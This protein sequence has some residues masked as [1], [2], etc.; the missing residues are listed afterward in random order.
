MLLLLL[1]CNN[2]KPESIPPD[3]S[4][5][6]KIDTEL[7]PDDSEDSPQD[8]EE[9]DTKLHSDTQ[10]ESKHS[11]DTEPPAP[12]YTGL[13]LYPTELTVG[14]GAIL[15][16][17]SIA[18]DQDGKRQAMLP[19]S[20]SS[21]DPA[22]VTVDAAGMITAVGEGSTTIRALLGGV[23][24]SA[25]FTVRADG[26]AT[27][28]VIRGDSGDAIKGVD[29]TVTDTLGNVTTA[30]TDELGQASI[31]VADGGAVSLTAYKSDNF[32][33]ISYLGTVSRDMLLLMQPKD[34]TGPEASIYGKVD[35]SGVADAAWDEIVLGMA[36]TSVQGDLGSLVVDSLFSED[37]AIN[38]I[39]FDVTAPSNL[40]VEDTAEDFYTNAWEGVVG[41]WGLAGPLKVSDLP[42]G[43]GAGEA[44]AIMVANLDKF[45]WDF[46]GGGVAD[47]DSEIELDLA[48]ADAFSDSFV[49]E[50]PALPAGFFGSEQ[51]FL[52]AA[53]ED[54]SD[55][56]FFD[57]FGS[58]LAGDRT[59]VKRVAP[60]TVANS[61]G[62]SVLIYNQV[63][64]LGSGGAICSSV[65]EVDGLVVVAPPLQDV[66]TISWDS[67]TLVAGYVADPDASYVRLR[68][69][70]SG[71]KQHD[72]YVPATSWTGTVPLVSA[73]WETSK[74][75][76]E[77]VALES[78]WGSFEDRV[79]TGDWEPRN[80]RA[81]S[82]ARTYMNN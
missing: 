75:D 54:A 52:M 71:K 50:L 16:L 23:E 73:D 25:V 77:V 20:F 18:T 24:G 32:V 41:V 11:E 70:D 67:S 4:E 31:A 29:I 43:A 12:V 30:S 63:G 78:S 57:G 26:M 72:I 51:Y 35:F 27:V 56:W 15:T 69:L 3:D 76:L 58:G 49:V 55:G 59:E 48:P 7:I 34:N 33:Q 21:D 2:N 64:G 10:V 68:L 80:Q 81:T 22:I 19:E 53:E 44:L 28:T 8:S 65:A 1:A 42:L 39:G 17:R 37:R 66:I 45:V 82:M 14:L 79:R 60:G 62:S 40:F 5:P 36:G 6:I 47:V 13:S 38:I 61:V 74:T 9:S 46:T